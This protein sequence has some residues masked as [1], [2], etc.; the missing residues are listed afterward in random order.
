MHCTKS[1]SEKIS[2]NVRECVSNDYKLDLVGI[3]GGMTAQKY[4]D[5]I[6]RSHVEP[7]I[8]NQALADIPLFMQG[9][10]KIRT[11]RIY[12]DALANAAIDLILWPSKNPDTNIFWKLLFYIF[13]HINSMDL[14]PHFSDVIMSAIASRL[15]PQPFVE[16]QIKENI[17]AVRH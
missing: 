3:L 9:G 14:L 12:Q 2:I 5:E 11:A 4:I 6:L 16:A 10:A 13:R 8:D 17:K 15:F 7:H 1:P